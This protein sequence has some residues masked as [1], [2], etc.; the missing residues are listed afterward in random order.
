MLTADNDVIVSRLSSRRV[1]N[2]CGE[3]VNLNDINNPDVCPICGA[4]ESLSKRK[5][6]EESVIKHRLNV[7][8]ES[9]IPVLDFYRDKF[10]IVTVKGTDPIDE[11]TKGIIELIEK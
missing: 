10:D 6:D 2:E 4:A 9:T 11:V 1:C 5:D 7:Y 8:R 3:I